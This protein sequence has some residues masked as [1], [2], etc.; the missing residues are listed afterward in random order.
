[1]NRLYSQA[2]NT[3]P[4]V[5]STAGYAPSFSQPLRSGLAT[6]KYG[7]LTRKCLPAGTSGVPCPQT[8]AAGVPPPGP[9]PVPLQ[10]LS[11]RLTCGFAEPLTQLG[12]AR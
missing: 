11:R 2:T 10:N 3:A 5:G 8:G 12:D 6:E 1:M 7:L 4:V 9:R